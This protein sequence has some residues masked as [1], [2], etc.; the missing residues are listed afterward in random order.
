MR[1]SIAVRAMGRKVVMSSGRHFNLLGSNN[2]MTFD[3]ST[4]ERTS[5]K[6]NNPA[7]RPEEYNQLSNQ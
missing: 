4:R 6:D 7:S 1:R 5:G 2:P 3:I